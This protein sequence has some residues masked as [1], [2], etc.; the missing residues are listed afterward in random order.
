MAGRS[1][2]LVY[3]WD[4]S[5]AVRP[6]DFLKILQRNNKISHISVQ[7]LSPSVVYADI[8][9]KPLPLLQER[10]IA[11]FIVTEG[12]SWMV[13]SKESIERRGLNNRRDEAAGPVARRLPLPRVSVRDGD[14]LLLC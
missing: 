12:L 6:L 7:S 5:N 10:N 1:L 8:I 14:G 11:I 9:T 4:L 3:L 2:L 13:V